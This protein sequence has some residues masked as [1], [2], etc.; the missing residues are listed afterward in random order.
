MI[1]VQNVGDTSSFRR[2]NTL[3][4]FCTNVILTGTTTVINILPWLFDIQ[5]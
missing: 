2:E 1:G 5:F 4:L 3:V